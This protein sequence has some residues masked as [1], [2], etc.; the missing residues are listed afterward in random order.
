M[1]FR[2]RQ[3]IKQ[4]RQLDTVAHTRVGS[5]ILKVL[6]DIKTVIC[7]VKQPNGVFGTH[8]ATG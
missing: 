6:A 2:D 7:I 8:N 4:V 5:F 3:K 1:R